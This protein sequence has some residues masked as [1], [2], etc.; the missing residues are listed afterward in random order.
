ME[1]LELLPLLTD[2][3]HIRLGHLRGFPDLFLLL[4]GKFAC[5]FFVLS[6]RRAHLA[7]GLQDLDL[8]VIAP[9]HELDRRL[10]AKRVLKVRLWD[11]QGPARGSR[12]D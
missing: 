4:R 10:L 7:L 6:H 2:V 1:V 5:Q 9:N 12:T 8:R 11:L 3:L